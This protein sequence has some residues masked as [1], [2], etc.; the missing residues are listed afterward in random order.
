ML[1]KKFYEL[2]IW[3]RRLFLG[4]ILLNFIALAAIAQEITVTGTV[5]SETEGALPGTTVVEKGTTNGTVTAADGN[6]SITVSGSESV[7]VFSF[8]G[9]ETQEIV[10]G[11]Q[12]VIN[13]TLQVSTTVLDEIVVTGYGTQ[14]RATVTTS[15]SKVDADDLRTT[16]VTSNPAVSLIGKVAGISIVE[17]DGRPHA[18]P[19][20]WIRG[21]TDF[22]PT[23]DNPLFVIDG[24][25][26]HNT[27]NNGG[28][29]G[30]DNR[31]DF[32]SAISDINPDDIESNDAITDYDFPPH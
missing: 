8:V 19:Q 15:I 9:Y 25:P 11:N 31:T 3:A 32:G 21:G 18:S 4:T 28:G 10:V 13:T 16:P 17:T 2:R 5:T 1:M 12:S 29:F 27:L 24:V 14:S 30:T 26:V 20:I 22:G 6:Y 23:N 7:L